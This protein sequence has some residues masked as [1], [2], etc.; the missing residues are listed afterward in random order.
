MWK[1]FHWETGSPDPNNWNW[2]EKLLEKAQNSK[3]KEIINQLYRPNASVG[4]G[5]TADK[6]R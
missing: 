1:R 3:L 5:G 2:R 4:D 6:L